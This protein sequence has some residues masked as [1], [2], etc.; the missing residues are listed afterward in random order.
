MIANALRVVRSRRAILPDGERAAAIHVVDGR[1]TAVRDYDDVPP[2]A[3]VI[4]AGPHVLLPGLVDSH[5]HENE[6]GRTEWEGFATATRAAVAG[7]VTTIVDMPLNSLPPTTDVSA[8]E[9]KRVAAERGVSCDVGFWGGA[10]PGNTDDLFPLH[11]AGVFGFKAFLCDSG[12]PEFPPLEMEEI[13]ATLERIAALRSVLLVHAENPDALRS[14]AEDVRRHATWLASRPPAAEEEAIGWLIELARVHGGR[15]HVVH[16]SAAGALP[17]IARARES[18]VPISVETCPHYLVLEAEEIP[19]GATLCKCA[20]PIREGANRE[21]LWQGLLDGTIDAIVS[22][23]S[24]SPPEGKRLESGDFVGA[25]GG[26][27]SLGLG[28][29]LVW[30]EL[31]RRAI[32]LEAIALWMCEGPAAIAGLEGKKGRIAEGYDADFAIFDPDFER[33]LEAGALN[34]RHK[35]SPYLGRRVKGV[36]R[37]TILRGETVYEGGAWSDTPRGTLLTRAHTFAR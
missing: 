34:F 16:L 19:E 29:P 5:V 11:A 36:V 3:E 18:G 26:I 32:S 35:V 24:P 20:P 25:W 14:P 33:T 6:P 30:T 2:G 8:L 1:I 17:A 4:D 7:G 28:L 27:A 37:R 22:D 21:A 12:V 13:D 15:V 31:E 9:K 10:V 23:H